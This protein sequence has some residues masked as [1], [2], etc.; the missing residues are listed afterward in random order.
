MPFWMGI[1][2]TE[3]FCGVRYSS[4]RPLKWGTSLVSHEG[5]I[6][7]IA[8]SQGGRDAGLHP[9]ILSAGS[10][11]VCSLI[12]GTARLIASHAVCPLCKLMAASLSQGVISYS[13]GGGDHSD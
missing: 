2:A 3:D 10:D 5:P 8:A 6:W 9:F 7:D 11:G 4:F 13:T 1:L 12:S